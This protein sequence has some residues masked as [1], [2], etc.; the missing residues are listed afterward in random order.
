MTHKDVGPPEKE[1][2]GGYQAARP[3]QQISNDTTNTANDNRS[4]GR[5]ACTTPL[6]GKGR[7]VAHGGRYT[8]RTPVP[9][10]GPVPDAA[11]VFVGTLLWSSPADAA[12]V[13]ELVADD[14]IESPALSVVLTSVRVLSV[15]GRPCDAQ[16]VMDEL[17]RGGT[18]RRDVALALMDAT[19]AG[20]VPEA[21]QYYGAAVVSASLRRRVESAG[22][23]LTSAADS[24]AESDLAPLVARAAAAVT[25]C[26]ARLAKLRGEVA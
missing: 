16:M 22:H 18:V 26:A 9:A 2:P 6:V 13:L 14:D 10:V 12:R 7:N 8:A 1:R 21:A 17:R 24:A 15:A 5:A 23:A 19:T 3:D 20:A 11:T 25:D 4:I